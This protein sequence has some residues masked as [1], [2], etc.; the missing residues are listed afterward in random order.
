MQ[1]QDT[2][3]LS[4]DAWHQSAFDGF[5]GHQAHGPARLAF[6]RI[7]AYHRDDTLL[8]VGVQHLDR[9][10][11]LFLIQSTLQSSLLVAMAQASN[12]LRRE[13][14]HL[15]DLRSTGLP[16]QLQKRQGPQNHPDLLYPT[17][18]QGS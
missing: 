15:G 9:A 5:F 13:R 1:Q 17:L 16:A 12:G 2:N 10:G 4:S 18:Q 6:G 14:N 7:A 3:G 8:L 11:T